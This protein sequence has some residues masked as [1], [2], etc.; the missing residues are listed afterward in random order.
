[1]HIRVLVSSTEWSNFL[2]LRD[3]PDAEPHIA[4][5]AQEIRKELDKPVMQVLRPGDWHTPFIDQSSDDKIHNLLM[6]DIEEMPD[7]A[8]KATLNFIDLKIKNSVSCCASTS[9]KTVDGFDMTLEKA[10][11]LHDKL[12]G[13]SPLHASPAE[14]VAQADWWRFEDSFG[15]KQEYWEVPSQH[16]NF[17]GFRQYRKMLPNECL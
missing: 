4:M 15:G 13:S 8:K 1:M 11:E 14:H 6:M 5:L 3:H 7:W 12:V 9:Y 2:A 16:G 17:V 10:I